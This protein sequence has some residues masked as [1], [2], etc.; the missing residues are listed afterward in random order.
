MT[1]ATE[2]VWLVE[3]EYS[4]KGLLTL[5][6]AT[7]DGERYMQS[8]RSSN[9]LQGAGVT[10]AKEASPDQLQPVEDPDLRERYA[11]EAARVAEN[12]A[13]DDEI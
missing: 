12:N 9:M 4:D 2:R 6:Y 3:R 11:T 10:A 13:P 7:P 5:V 8:N 1:E